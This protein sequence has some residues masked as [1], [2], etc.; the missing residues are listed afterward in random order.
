MRETIHKGPLRVLR[1]GKEAG[2]NLQYF[3]VFNDVVR[4]V[5]SLRNFNA[6]G[7]IRECMGSDMQ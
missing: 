1:V 4:A 2:V 7:T 5:F 3:Y 6:V